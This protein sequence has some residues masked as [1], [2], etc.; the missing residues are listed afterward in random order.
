M[1]GRIC[2]G[3]EAS[4]VI[5]NYLCFTN[6]R[7]EQGISEKVFSASTYHSR[8]IFGILYQVGAISCDII[9]IYWT[10]TSCLTTEYTQQI[11]ET[12][13]CYLPRSYVQLF[14]PEVVTIEESD[15]ELDKTLPKDKYVYAIMCYFKSLL[16][17]KFN[18][19]IV[20][21]IGSSV[22]KHQVLSESSV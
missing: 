2:R 7:K 5:G 1:V 13:I 8:L 17:V 15:D 16:I 12:N 14:E 21:Q 4:F 18:R 3:N 9:Q 11:H 10:S 20:I 19:G 22:F 6:T